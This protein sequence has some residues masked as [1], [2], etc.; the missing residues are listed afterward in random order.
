MLSKKN[1]VIA[2]SLDNGRLAMQ[3]DISKSSKDDCLEEL[4]ERKEKGEL[5]PILKNPKK[6]TISI[7]SNI[8]EFFGEK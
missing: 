8:E 1:S 2:E 3:Y 6:S 7:K 5:N 4:K